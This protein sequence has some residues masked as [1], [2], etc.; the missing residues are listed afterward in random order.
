MAFAEAGAFCDELGEGHGGGELG[1]G[2]L[3]AGVF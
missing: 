1:G 3:D 2:D